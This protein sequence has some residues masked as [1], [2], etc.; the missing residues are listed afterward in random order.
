M[1]IKVVCP[2]CKKALNAPDAMAGKKVK[3]PGCMAVMD[4]PAGIAAFQG[5][6][7]LAAKPAAPPAAAKPAAPLAAAAPGPATPPAKGGNACPKCK[8][9]LPADAIICV[10][11]GI[12]I[13]T[14]DK[15]NTSIG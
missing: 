9:S 10:A 7:K 14:G 3:C 15:F 1:P 13:R 4:V 8:K 6:T 2:K 5:E 11:C 12:N